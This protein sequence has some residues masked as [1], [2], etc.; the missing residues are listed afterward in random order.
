MI[1]QHRQDRDQFL[2]ANRKDSSEW[3]RL[4]VNQAAQLVALNGSLVEKRKI[5]IERHHQETLQLKRRIELEKK[6]I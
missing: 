2:I 3:A 5:I 6:G 4:L 1:D